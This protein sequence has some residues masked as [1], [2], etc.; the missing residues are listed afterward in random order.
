MSHQEPTKKS[1]GGPA[2]SRIADISVGDISCDNP[3]GSFIDVPSREVIGNRL[4]L[5]MELE[6]ARFASCLRSIL[7]EVFNPT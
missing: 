6:L 5:E 1:V 7:L 2:R 4:M 3:E